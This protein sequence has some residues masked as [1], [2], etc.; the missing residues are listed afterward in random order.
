MSD[1]AV[2]PIPD[3]LNFRQNPTP[4][5]RDEDLTFMRQWV[6]G[7][8]SG[9]T[10]AELRAHVQ[11][12]HGEVVAQEHVYRC[13]STMSY[14]TPRA[15]QHPL[16][17]EVLTA[18]R[19]AGDSYRLLE[20]GACFGQDTRALIM[21]GVPPACITVTD[22]HDRYWAAGLRL[23]QDDAAR[24]SGHRLTGVTTLFG[25]W[26]AEPATVDI[27]EGLE[28]KFDAVLCWA[29]LHVLSATQVE[30]MLARLARVLKP[31][32][33]LFGCTGGA[34]TAQEWGPTPDGTAIRWL[35][36]K[37]S[38]ATTLVTAGFDGEV[39]VA[40]VPRDRLPA[41]RP[42]ADSHRVPGWG[43]LIF[44]ACKTLV[45][46]E[47]LNFLREWIG[48]TG[49]S[50]ETLR[51]HVLA[52]HRDLIRTEH[53]FKC[54]LMMTYLTPRARRHPAYAEV[55][56]AAR[57]A[58]D[59]FRLLEVGTCF[60]QDTRALIADGVPPGCITATDLHGRYWAG[61]LRLFMDDVPRPT[62]HHVAGVATVFGD[63]TTDP[64][65]ADIAAGLEGR[66]DA[67]LCM[68][69]LHVLSAVQV[70]RLLA[71]LARVL[72]PGG[73]LF[74][75]AIGAATPGEWGPTPDGSGQ[76]WLHNP[77]SLTDTL[78]AS[79]FAGAVSVAEVPRE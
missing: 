38:L 34:A 55:V 25:D 47:D 37:R 79:G 35:H 77:Q 13:I 61:G 8:D 46:D 23:F 70:E 1:S 62:G 58:G 54:I 48:D 69:V 50:A 6:G 24:P 26:S 20:V 73:V 31:G 3:S 66:F 51:R 22:L 5:L 19:S 14:L 68:M 27:A 21:D 15:R 42:G 29:V 30:R 39:S 78:R 65:V 12:V 74:G 4:E 67:V 75:S 33:V 64:A 57:E 10:V 32:G 49:A 41:L 72:K 28:E 71:R 17:A 7:E 53:A 76:R 44:T 43:F 18:A 45:R 60:G 9:A 11:A 63:W 2:I 16:Y 52:V 56:T 59:S 40:E 36:D